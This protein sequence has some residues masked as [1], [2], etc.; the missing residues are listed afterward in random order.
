MTQPGV[1]SPM[2]G[3]HLD[4]QRI[5]EDFPILRTKVHGKDLVYLDNA[6]TAQK[7]RAMI[8]AVQAPRVPPT[9]R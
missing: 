1:A 3:P 7:P 4:V 6:A 9:P 8:D 2:T 5:R